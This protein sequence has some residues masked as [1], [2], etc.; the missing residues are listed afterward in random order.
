MN[1]NIECCALFPETKENYV[2]IITV[3]KRIAFSSYYSL[4]PAFEMWI[5]S[6]IYSIF[7]LIYFTNR[8]RSI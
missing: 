4:S 7:S 2:M 6:A 5:K 1:V 3:A 8:F